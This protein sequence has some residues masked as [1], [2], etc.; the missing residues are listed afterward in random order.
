MKKLWKEGISNIYVNETQLV[1]DTYNGAIIYTVQGDCC[2]HSYWA[3]IMHPE[4]IL[5]HRIVGI[6]ELESLEGEATTQEVDTIY[7][8][9]LKSDKAGGLNNCIITF[10]NSSNG[11]YG[12]C[13]DG[14][15]IADI[16][17]VPLENYKHVTSNYVADWT[18]F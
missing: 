4:A 8:Y 2:S 14:G 16:H 15:E 1:F 18:I 3:E 5:N 13:C 7:G 17:D 11:Y 6:E 12:G 9:K 10:R